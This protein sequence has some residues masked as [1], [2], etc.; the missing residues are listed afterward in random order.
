MNE[1]EK[2]AW[3][4]ALQNQDMIF[5]ITNSGHGACAYDPE[6]KEAVLGL[7]ANDEALG[8]AVREALACSRYLSIDE[9]REFLDYRR[10]EQR[11]N[12][13]VKSLMEKQG[14][15]TR[16][17]LFK[18]MKRCGI[19]MSKGVIEISPTIHRS[20]EAWGK[21]RSDGIE[22]IRIPA[23]ASPAKIGAALR[24]GFSRCRE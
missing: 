18:R 14:Y 9:V 21:D 17:A 19:E 13:W 10:V 24:L 2:C 8:V 3:A 7:D 1:P 15:K 22:N 23:D 12:E 6:G 11:Y 16:V 5:I 20:L 4:S